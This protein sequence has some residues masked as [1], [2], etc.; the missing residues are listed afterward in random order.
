M[1]KYSHVVF[2]IVGFASR[3][4][5]PLQD[6]FD[7]FDSLVQI[8]PTVEA[9]PNSLLFVAARKALAS[10]TIRNLMALLSERNLFG[11]CCLL[12]C[13]PTFSRELI[14]TVEPVILVAS[15]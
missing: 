6:L 11:N 12:N 15:P 13:F 3:I 10:A 7:A 14:L 9:Q 4:L 1:V 5:D 2:N 8:F